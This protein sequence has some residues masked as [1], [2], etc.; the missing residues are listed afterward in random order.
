MG[1]GFFG[2]DEARDRE[3]TQADREMGESVL[4]TV[5]VL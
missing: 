2:L 5:H 3:I 4:K 1:I